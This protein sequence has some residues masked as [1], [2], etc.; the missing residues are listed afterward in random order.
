MT[1]IKNWNQ[2]QIIIYFLNDKIVLF[3]FLKNFYL[4]KEI[5]GL[6]REVFPE[7]PLMVNF[8]IFDLSVANKDSKY[9]ILK[10]NQSIK[11]LS[12]DTIA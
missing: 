11:T 12:E 6:I 9:P 7:I 2:S 5:K 4:R 8:P 1:Y 10:A 3:Q